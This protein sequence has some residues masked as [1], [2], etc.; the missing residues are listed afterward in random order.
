MNFEQFMEEVREA[1]PAAEVICATEQPLAV[2][3]D[4]HVVNP[5]GLLAAHSPAW[6]WLD[7]LAIRADGVD[8]ALLSVEFP[9]RANL[10]TGVIL[11]HGETQ[12]E[13]TVV[14]DASGKGELEIVS[15][16]PGEI[17]ISVKDKPVRASVM[18]KEV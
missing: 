11:R 17:L 16:T 7:K 3:I 8:A 9:A 5:A 4:G 14:L 15:S 13:E 2:V 18:V 1:Y 10:S 12:V 6:L